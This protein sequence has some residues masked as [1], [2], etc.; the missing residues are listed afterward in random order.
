MNTL[1]NGSPCPGHLRAVNTGANAAHSSQNLPVHR[2]NGSLPGASGINAPSILR[3]PETIPNYTGNDGIYA[4]R[5]APQIISS[6]VVPD[7]EYIR[8][9]KQKDKNI[10]VELSQPMYFSH[11]SSSRNEVMADIPIHPTNH[12]DGFGIERSVLKRS[13]SDKGKSSRTRTPSPRP[14]VVQ[15]ERVSSSYYALGSNNN[16]RRKYTWTLSADILQCENE[17]K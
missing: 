15:E 4:E 3:K 1:L 7:S 8:Y 14:D 10:P 6:V 17:R 5:N 2:V 11:L 13:L 12:P 9:I 16:N